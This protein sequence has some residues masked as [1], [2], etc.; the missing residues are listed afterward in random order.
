VGAGGLWVGQ[1]QRPKT[2]KGPRPGIF[3]VFLWCFRAPLLEIAQKHDLKKIEKNPPG[4]WIFWV[5]FCKKIFDTI[6]L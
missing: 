4:F 1:S 3:L 2:K 5:D 6:V